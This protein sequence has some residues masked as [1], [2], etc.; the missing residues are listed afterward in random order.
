MSLRSS[1]SLV[2]AVPWAGPL[3]LQRVQ[4]VVPDEFRHPARQ[5]LSLSS[6]GSFLPTLLSPSFDWSWN[7]SAKAPVFVQLRTDRLSRLKGVSTPARLPA[8]QGAERQDPLTHQTY[9][10]WGV[11]TVLSGGVP[12][13]A[14]NYGRF[15]L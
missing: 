1:Y 4:P 11:N 15:R 12:P 13:F 6:F 3:P 10:L 14:W 2:V 8:R 7:P 5:A 9:F